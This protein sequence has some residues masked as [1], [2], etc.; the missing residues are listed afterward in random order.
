MQ[1]A[2]VEE[3]TAG[4]LL[5]T[6]LTKKKPSIGTVRTRA[7]SALCSPKHLLNA[8]FW[9]IRWDFGVWED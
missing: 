2:E 6:K 3:K 4:A 5:L 9:I 1:V 8:C 7:S